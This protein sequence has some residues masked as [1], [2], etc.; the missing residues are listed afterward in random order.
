MSELI[1]SQVVKG[2]SS[3]S[4]YQPGKPES[5]LKRELGLDS[6]IKLA[7]NENPL[8]CSPQVQKTLSDYF[9]NANNLAIYPDGSGHGLKTAL[10][11]FLS[12]QNKTIAAQQITLGS[13]SNDVL[14]MIVRTFADSDAE[15]VMS[16]YAFA[17]YYIST[18]AV[19]AKAVIVPAQ[20]HGHDLDAMLAAI[21][22]KTKVVFIAN[23]NNPTGTWLDYEAIVN[24]IKKVPAHVMVVVDEAYSEYVCAEDVVLNNV[25]SLMD[26]VSNFENLIV[27]RTFSKVY[28]LASLRVGYAVSSAQIADY[29]NRV[30]H[31]F[32][33]NTIALL[34]AEV[35]LKDQ[36]FVAQSAALNYQQ[37]LHWYQA[38][39]ALGLEYIASAGNFV[40]IKLSSDVVAHELNQFLLHAGIIVRDLKPYKMP[41]FLRITIGDEKQNQ[42]TIDSITSFFQK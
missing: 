11:E 22:E 19:G 40:T 3:L 20:N 23:P 37:K 8:G 42:M 35:A 16:Q 24:F 21:T 25:S 30:R 1:A 39:D 15:V 38:L 28:G 36:E 31:P 34:A 33:V 27:T 4:P 26:D 18:Q 6:I 12:H 13:G 14:D 29:L 10:S 41:E 7:S 5:E 17:V 9:A 32:N 2:V